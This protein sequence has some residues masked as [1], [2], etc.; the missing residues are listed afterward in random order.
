MVI[1][2]FSD[3]SICSIKLKCI[4]VS[5]RVLQNSSVS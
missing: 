5:E 4:K 3:R 1:S 2:G